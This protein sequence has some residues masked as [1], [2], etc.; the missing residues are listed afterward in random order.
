MSTFPIG[1]SVITGLE[2]VTRDE[3]N[4]KLKVTPEIDPKRGKVYFE[5]ESLQDVHKVTELR[6][7]E[8]VF[9]IAAKRSTDEIFGTPQSA[10][11]YF[12][13][14]PEDIDWTDALQVCTL[15]LSRA[16]IC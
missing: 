13:R 2:K 15:K 5:I 8:K 6:S 3:V 1:C 10:E 4:E 12:M 16:R 7:V 11:K 9:S 14:L